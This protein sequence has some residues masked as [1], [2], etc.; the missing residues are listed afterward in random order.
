MSLISCAYTPALSYGHFSEG[1]IDA[2]A[3]DTHAICVPSGL[4]EC[5]RNIL[6]LLGAVVSDLRLRVE[7]VTAGR[8]FQFQ[9]H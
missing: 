6:K 2:L 3:F 7:Y 4:K 8:E 5:M 9:Q 1:Q